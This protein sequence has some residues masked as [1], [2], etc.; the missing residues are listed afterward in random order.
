MVQVVLPPEALRV[1]ARDFGVKHCLPKLA[2]GTR[3][4]L[5]YRLLADQGQPRPRRRPRSRYFLAPPPPLS[6]AQLQALRAMEPG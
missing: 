2:L 6:A 3:P 1:L 4:S 5:G